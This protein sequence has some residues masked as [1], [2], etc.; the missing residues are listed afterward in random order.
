MIKRS[1]EGQNCPTKNSCTKREKE[2]LLTPTNRQLFFFGIYQYV[3]KNSQK[4]KF[5]AQNTAY[6]TCICAVFLN[7]Y[8][9]C[10]CVYN[11]VS[12]YSL[13]DYYLEKNHDSCGI[14]KKLKKTYYFII[15][16]SWIHTWYRY[17]NRRMRSSITFFK[18]RDTYIARSQRLVFRNKDNNKDLFTSDRWT[19]PGGHYLAQNGSYPLCD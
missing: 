12:W 2:I 8:G 3:I 15:L 11:I 16:T 1:K 10:V 6:A 7:M 9:V 17:L 5:W 4:S 19:R 13:A 14:L 18:L